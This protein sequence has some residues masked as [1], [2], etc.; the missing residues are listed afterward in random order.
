MADMPRTSG[1]ELRSGDRVRVRPIGPADAPELRRAFEQLSERSRYER[2]FTGMR[3]LPDGLLRTLTDV[4]HVDH[5]ALVAVP[6][7]D[8]AT[9]VGV[10]RFVRDESARSTA[11][12]AVTVAD[13]WQGRGL[14]TCLLRLLSRRA[15]EV[16][17]EHFTV[18]MLA[19]NRAVLAL[20]H[21]AGGVQT[22]NH[23]STVASR[24]DV[25]DQI[26]VTR[27]DIAEVLRAVAR[28]E[29]LTLPRPIR[30]ALPAAYAVARAL[31]VP[32]TT[33]LAAPDAED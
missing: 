14:G 28:G 6:S 7:Q 32:T 4:D 25:D 19:E 31:L 8:P 15:S 26:D 29:M 23:G 27:C 11:D 9:I 24:I 12:L 3:T 20:V 18:D 22:A 17:V 21:S 1:V 30:Q 16:G 33:S 2:F 13:D 5:E 10:A